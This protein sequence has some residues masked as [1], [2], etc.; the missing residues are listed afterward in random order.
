MQYTSPVVQSPSDALTSLLFHTRH[1]YMYVVKFSIFNMTAIQYVCL[2]SF[3]HVYRP[4]NHIV[5]ANVKDIY[6]HILCYKIF[7]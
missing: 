4:S 5:N 2:V 3:T 6:I 1:A 7:C